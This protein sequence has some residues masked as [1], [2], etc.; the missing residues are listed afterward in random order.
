MAWIFC[1]H[2]IAYQR[3][4]SV[5]VLLY[6][7]RLSTIPAFELLGK[8]SQSQLHVIK[9][10]RVYYISFLCPYVYLF[11]KNEQVCLSCLERGEYGRLLSLL[12]YSAAW[13][14][15]WPLCQCSCHR[16]A[17]VVPNE[18]SG[19]HW[20][21]MSHICIDYNTLFCCVLLFREGHYTLGC[22]KH[23]FLRW[24]S[25]HHICYQGKSREY[26]DGRI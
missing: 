18:L 6:G 14:Q 7:K 5:K 11:M 16:Q 24:T 9:M 22:S 4:Q 1:R 23:Q 2:V 3:F 17:C 8:A 20:N 13:H 12:M 15:T 19:I 26:A 21:N 25:L 10:S